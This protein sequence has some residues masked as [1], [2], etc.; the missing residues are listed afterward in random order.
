MINRIK[1]IVFVIVSLLMIFIILF[2]GYKRKSKDNDFAFSSDVQI[3]YNEDNIE[4]K[5]STMNIKLQNIVKKEPNINMWLANIKIKNPEQIKSAFAGDKFTL[6]NKEKT[7]EIAKRNNAIIAINGSAYGFNE[8]GFV[9][10]DKVLYRDTNLDASPLVIK[11]NGDFEI[12]NYGEK[13]GQEMLDL[14]AMHVYDFGPDLIRYGDIVDYGDSWY[15]NDKQPRTVIGQK[16]ELEYVII[17][18]DGRSKE[19]EGISLYDVALELKNRGCYVGYNLDGGGSTTLYFNGEVL[20]NP[21]DLL[22]E[23]KISD[24]LYFID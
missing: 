1:K 6:E 14:G 18:V 19:S 3:K 8:K 7:S 23:R 20:N 4:Y 16:G 24:I 22:G 10:R 13:T 11:D 12:Y 15:K 2:I 17:V 21:S 5:S 9:I